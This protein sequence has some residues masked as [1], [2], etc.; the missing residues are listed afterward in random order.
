MRFHCKSITWSCEVNL[1]NPG[2]N[3]N[4][5]IICDQCKEREVRVFLTQVVGQTVKEVQLCPECAREFGLDD[6]PSMVDLARLLGSTEYRQTLAAA[7]GANPRYPIEAYEFVCEALDYCRQWAADENETINHVSGQK[8]L[9]FIRELARQKLG[10]EAKTVLS[11]WKIYR[12]EDFGEIVFDMVDAGS[13]RLR[14]HRAF[15]RSS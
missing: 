13:R 1:G 14:W 2:Y 7:L 11:G 4:K 8:L 3:L 15:L 5:A 9:E 6:G 12:T 10:K